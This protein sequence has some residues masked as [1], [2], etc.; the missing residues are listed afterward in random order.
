[1]NV[2]FKSRKLQR[3]F[4][5]SSDAA[6]EWGAVVGRK[7][8]QR[9]IIIQAAETLGDLMSTRSLRCHQLKGKRAGTYAIDLTKSVRLIFRIENPNESIV[10]MEVT[11]YHDD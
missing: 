10:V 1:M 2:T 11:D 6:K 4:E 7:Y 8:V 9:I 3:C 5:Q